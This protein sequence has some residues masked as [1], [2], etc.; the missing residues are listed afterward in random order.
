LSN[1]T[2]KPR[3]KRFE[4]KL[5]EDRR[6]ALIAATLEC[7][8]RDGLGGLSI[9]RI[10]AQAQVSI[11]LIN[12][13]FPD[14]DSLVAAAYRTFNSELIDG[15]RRAVLYAPSAPRARLSAFLRASFS[16]PNLDRDVLAVWVVFWGL[17][18]HSAQIQRV[19]SEMSYGYGDLLQTLLADLAR[20]VGRLRISL[21]LAAIGLTAMLDG[22]WL[23]WCLDPANFVPDEAVA[24]CEA[25]VDALQVRG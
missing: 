7:L 8:K 5:P 10:S 12:H 22:L 18:R 3:S 4:R 16:P 9:R 1:A 17:L 21:R 13:H 11:G 23:E 15:F 25:W 6:R 14:K 24:L 2:R 19:H 20:E